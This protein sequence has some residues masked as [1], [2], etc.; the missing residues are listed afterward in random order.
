M[1]SPHNEC[2]AVIA[3]VDGSDVD[4]NGHAVGIFRL[5]YVN[6]GAGDG[7]GFADAVADVLP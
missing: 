4:E 6:Y 3:G 7:A 2:D 1:L 5:V